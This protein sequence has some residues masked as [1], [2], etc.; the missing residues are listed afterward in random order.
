MLGRPS[1]KASHVRRLR[2]TTTPGAERLEPKQL[3][4]VF[5]VT[6]TD[7]TGA[8]SLREAIAAANQLPG[9]DIINFNIDPAGPQTI[10]LQSALSPITDTLTIDGTTQPGFDPSNP[11]PMI[12]LDGS[13]AGVFDTGLD[14]RESS[15]ASN[16]GGT[17]S[18]VRGLA[19]NG[20]ARNGIALRGEGHLIE[21]NVIGLG[22]DGVTVLPN[23]GDGISLL[24]ASRVTIGGTDALT[25]NIISG[26][27]SDGI[28]IQGLRSTDSAFN[29]IIGNSIGTD[30]TG[31]IAIGNDDNG[32]FLFGGGLNTIGGQ[33]PSERNVISGNG[34]YGIF[35][36]GDSA[37]QN[38]VIGNYI[39]TN[40]EGTEALGNNSG[41]IFGLGNGNTIGGR[42]PA[43]GT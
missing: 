4:A 34:Q 28:Q 42:R 5:T 14:F 15:G 35:F 37:S 31:T 27:G 36:Q 3:L 10:A 20:F 23:G 16:D 7:D 26:N 9:P 30:R 8:G 22:L 39:G 24:N 11:M 1:A 12:E 33:S 21:G 17:G 19:I 32:I 2:R 6:V 38:L 29:R 13:G 40:A 43:I 41:G 25:R 18:V